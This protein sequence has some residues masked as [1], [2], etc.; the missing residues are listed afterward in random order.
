VTLLLRGR[1]VTLGALEALLLP[2]AS[3][4]FATQLPV[5][6]WAYPSMGRANI[7]LGAVV[8]PAVV[9]AGI[10]AGHV[11]G[12]QY[13]VVECG[14][15]ACSLRRVRDGAVMRAT[16]TSKYFPVGTVAEVGGPTTGTVLHVALASGCSREVVFALVAHQPVVASKKDDL[17]RTPL[18]VA[19]EVTSA[20]FI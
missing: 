16:N 5:P 14:G 7:T 6:C 15:G 9:S 19:A 18:K 2:L 1:E 20:H 11:S 4:N 12:T 8:V 10:A 17:G 13:W 3:E